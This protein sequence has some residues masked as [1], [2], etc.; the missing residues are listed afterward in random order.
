MV[1]CHLPCSSAIAEHCMFA[2]RTSCQARVE[3]LLRKSP[4]IS[5]HLTK[6]HKICS[7]PR[8]HNDWPA[9]PDSGFD[10]AT[11]LASQTF[12]DPGGSRN[13]FGKWLHGQKR[14]IHLGYS[15]FRG[16][17]SYITHLKRLDGLCPTFDRHVMRA[18][19][20]PSLSSPSHPKGCKLGVIQHSGWASSNPLA[21]HAVCMLKSVLLSCDAARSWRF[22]GFKVYRILCKS[23]PSWPESKRCSDWGYEKWPPH[24]C[25]PKGMFEYSA[26]HSYR[27]WTYINPWSYDPCNSFFWQQ[28]KMLI[29]NQHSS[30]TAPFQWPDM[31]RLFP[32]QL[33]LRSQLGGTIQWL[34]G[35]APF[36]IHQG[37]CIQGLTWKFERCGMDDALHRICAT[38]LWESESM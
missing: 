26:A 20:S 15:E 10:N 22:V 1:C 2:P 31:T 37:S 27:C 7:R 35:G 3:A 36:L 18:L 21:L 4:E 24:S 17:F 9:D 6:F 19:N 5:P 34:V 38:M 29:A 8:R 13:T 16:E 28:T 33:G 30:T 23:H 12:H 32:T 11:K 25:K 14:S